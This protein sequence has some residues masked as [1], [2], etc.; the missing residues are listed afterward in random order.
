MDNVDNEM[1]YRKSCNDNANF[2]LISQDNIYCPLIK[3]S[4]DLMEI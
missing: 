4:H 1:I 3:W 2:L